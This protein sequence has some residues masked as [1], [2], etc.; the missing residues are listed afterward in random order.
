RKTAYRARKGIFGGGNART[1][2]QGT[3][4]SRFS[5][6]TASDLSVYGGTARYLLSA[7]SPAYSGRRG[8]DTEGADSRRCERGTVL[9]HHYGPVAGDTADHSLS[10]ERY[11]D[12][13]FTL[14]SL[15]FRLSRD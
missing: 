15:R 10:P 4:R 1:A 8:R 2:G 3:D 13:G 14:L 12:A 7:Q 11:S 9:S 6:T 5:E